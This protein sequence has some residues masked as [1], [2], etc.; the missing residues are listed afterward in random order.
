VPPLPAP[1]GPTTSTTA[2]PPNPIDSILR[3]FGSGGAR[4]GVVSAAPAARTANAAG[5]VADFL[6]GVARALTGVLG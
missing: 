6:K 2:A 5:G 3:L 4:V 1:P